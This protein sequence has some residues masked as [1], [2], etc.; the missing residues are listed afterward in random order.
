M[1][2]SLLAGVITVALL[3]LV[4]S[5]ALAQGWGDLTGTFVLK[6]KAPKPKSLKIAM[7]PGVAALDDESLTV[8]PKT[9]GIENIAIWLVPAKD[10]KVEVHPAVTAAL[11]APVIVD[12][13]GCRFV[14]RM[15][16]IATSQ[17]VN[18]TNTDKTGHNVKGDLLVNTPFN[19][20]L[21]MGG[22]IT[23]T[24]SK[25]EKFPATVSCGIHPW[26]KGY[27]VVKETPYFAV[28]DKVGAFKITNLPEGKWEFRAWHERLGNVKDVIIGG[29]D[30]TWK[31]GVFSETIASAA[32]TNLGTVQIDVSKFKED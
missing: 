30:V 5:P 15:S 21:P 16:V 6:G 23:Q 7:C 14:P 10:T 12:N 11:K 28:T 31:A 29:K 2:K 13:A 8:D 27:V 20:T 19:I 9:G 3:T 32:K 1:H 24:F 4:A 18:F 26:M 17:T 25:E 22:K